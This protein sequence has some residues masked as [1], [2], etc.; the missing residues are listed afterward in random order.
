ME[1]EDIVLSLKN[2]QENDIV[3]AGEDYEGVPIFVIRI[4][5]RVST[6]HIGNQEAADY[7]E[8]YDTE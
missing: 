5:N 1:V 2:I 4:G 3:E 6:L 8:F 7:P